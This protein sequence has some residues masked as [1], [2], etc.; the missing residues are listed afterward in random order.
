MSVPV[1][2]IAPVEPKFD[3]WGRYL[4]PDPDGK[5]RA[6]TRAT[7]VAKTLDDTYNLERW[8]MRQ[9]AYG[10]GKR[11]DL[12]AAAASHHPDTDRGKFDKLCESALE[13]A[14]SSAGATMGDALHKMTERLDRGD[15]QLADV[16]EQM[17]DLCAAY[18][19]RLTKAGITID[20]TGVERLI[21]H[22]DW[23]IAGTADRLPLILRDGT[24]VLGDL[25]TGKDLSFS[26]LS[27]AQQLA[28]YAT[29]TATYDGTTRGPRVK[30][31]TDRALVIHLPSRGP[32]VGTCRLHWIDIA[33]GY[34]AVLTSMETRERRKSAKALATPFDPND[35]PAKFDPVEQRLWL[36]GRV[37]A[38]ASAGALDELRNTWPT[39]VPQPLPDEPTESQVGAVAA[40][41]DRVEA[42]HQIP[43]GEP[44]PN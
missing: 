37:A 14:G 20:P 23:Q 10:I 21:L 25:K 39:G 28:I 6:Y 16:P 42:R 35:V 2:S 13:V 24:R 7:T 40:V 22:D 32:E 36:K 15:I 18:Q 9:V 19:R 44:Q 3:R 38:V 34:D 5:Q 30:V 11:A 17:R 26:W 41:L 27:I 31:D 4:L 33:E 1:D 29:H 43:F 8:K 12:Y